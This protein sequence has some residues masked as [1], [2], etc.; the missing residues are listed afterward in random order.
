MSGLAPFIRIGLRILGGYLVG[1]GL[2]DDIAAE[3]YSDEMVGA[4]VL[5]GNEVW[6]MLARRYGWA[7]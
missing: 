4:V 2:S 1:R 3:I 6:D 5:G 7:R